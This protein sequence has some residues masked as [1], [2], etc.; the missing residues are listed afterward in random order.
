MIE[1]KL[2]S[3]IGSEIRLKS[4]IG[5]EKDHGRGHTTTVLCKS[6]RSR[7]LT[8]NSRFS[9][10][11]QLRSTSGED[12]ANVETKEHGD[13]TPRTTTS[14]RRRSRSMYE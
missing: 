11:R 4:Y 6:T 9:S 13:L 3:Y 5:S 1:I 7:L 12:H 8:D 10:K 14:V 2:K